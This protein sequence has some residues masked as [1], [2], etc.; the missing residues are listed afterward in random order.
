MDRL[1]LMTRI[2]GCETD[3]ARAALIGITPRHWSRAREGHVGSVF[4]AN[5]IAALRQRE[6]EL[7]ARNLRPTF[8]ELFEVVMVARSTEVR[9]AA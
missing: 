4:V 7:V 6:R 5:T 9:A 1:E 8:D 3:T 2:L